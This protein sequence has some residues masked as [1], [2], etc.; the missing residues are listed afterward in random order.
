MS[1][2][3][4]PL[5][6]LFVLPFA[7]G[8]GGNPG[9][10]TLRGRGDQTQIA[11]IVARDSDDLTAIDLTTM[12]IVQS[13][14]IGTLSA[15][16]GELNLDGSKLYVDSEETNETVVVNTRDFTGHAQAPDAHH[17]HQRRQAAPGHGGGGQQRVRHR[18][19]DRPGD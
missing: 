7:A 15:H 3:T 11:Y 6:V 9:G 10:P 5:C 1:K 17:A 19:R 18:Q 12:S 2:S 14:R 8:C 13:A 16:M 4:I